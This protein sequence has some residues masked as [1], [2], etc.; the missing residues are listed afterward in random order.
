MGS[1]ARSD[2]NAS[3]K[4]TTENGNAISLS[5]IVPSNDLVNF[6]LRN[7]G[8]LPPPFRTLL[9][10]WHATACRNATWWYSHLS[11][12]D[13][14]LV[15]DRK[16]CFLTD[17]FS[18]YSFQLLSA[19]SGKLTNYDDVPLPQDLSEGVDE[20]EWVSPKH[21]SNM[22]IGVCLLAWLMASTLKSKT[23]RQTWSVCAFG[24]IHGLVTDIMCIL[25]FRMTEL[26]CWSGPCVRIFWEVFLK[27]WKLTYPSFPMII[28]VTLKTIL[29]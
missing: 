25:Y 11:K 15:T 1:H 13:E 10:Q 20:S 9:I 3:E 23:S 14:W 19:M 8:I 27:I 17:F 2:W 7:G 5:R 28:S 21:S 12:G 26:L 18:K 6:W 16:D 29:N 24:F 4:K 22:G